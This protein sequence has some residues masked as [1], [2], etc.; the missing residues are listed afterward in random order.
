MAPWGDVRDSGVRTQVCPPGSVHHWRHSPQEHELVTVITRKTLPSTFE[1]L[2]AHTL[3]LIPETFD[4]YQANRTQCNSQISSPESWVNG[5]WHHFRGT[6]IQNFSTD[7]CWSRHEELMWTCDGILE[8]L[9]GASSAA[10]SW[11][12]LKLHS[13]GC[14]S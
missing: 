12:A 14:I 11:D 6:H 4:K 3:N 13:Q 1:N 8:Y 10:V 7:P 2:H 9:I 5:A